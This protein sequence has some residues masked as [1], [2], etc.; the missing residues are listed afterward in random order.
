M[1]NLLN[2]VSLVNPSTNVSSVKMPTI[3]NTVP[4]AVNAST[5]QLFNASLG[6]LD[7][8]VASGL[9]IQED[10]SM[11]EAESDSDVSHFIVFY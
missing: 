1:F 4:P 9:V 10:H 7:T 8:S 5:S 11:D 6:S 3:Q 2:D